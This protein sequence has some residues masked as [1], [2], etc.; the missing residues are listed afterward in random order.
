MVVNSGSCLSNKTENAGIKFPVLSTLSYLT[1]RDLSTVMN[2]QQSRFWIA[3]SSLL[4]AW[5]IV[6]SYSLQRYKKKTEKEGKEIKKKMKMFL[7]NKKHGADE[8]L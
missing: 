6:S 1:Q 8:V 5:V 3:T 7:R 4:H 2:V